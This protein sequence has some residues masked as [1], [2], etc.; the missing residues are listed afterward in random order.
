MKKYFISNFPKNKLIII[1]VISLFI[2]IINI[3]YLVFFEKAKVNNESILIE[4]PYTI[5]N[6]PKP[7]YPPQITNTPKAMDYGYFEDGFDNIDRTINIVTYIKDNGIYSRKIQNYILGKEILLAQNFD[8]VADYT[9]TQD[10][11]F[12]AYSY[13]TGEIKKGDRSEM[14]GS[15]HNVNLLNIN[16]G[17]VKTIFNYEPTK[18]Q[19]ITLTSSPYKNIIFIG[20]DYKRLFIYDINLSKLIEITYKEDETFND[21]N[22]FCIGYKVFDQSPDLS[23]IL[24][25]GYCYE[26]YGFYLYNINTKERI[27]IGYNYAS[28]PSVKK[29][30]DNGSFL[31]HNYDDGELVN[32]GKY[33]YQNQLVQELPITKVDKD[34]DKTQKKI[35]YKNIDK[36]KNIRE[37]YLTSEKEIIE[38]HKDSSVLIKDNQLIGTDISLLKVF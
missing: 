9:L 30:I 25:R 16:T 38:N 31:V 24:L 18:G 12:I 35:Y 6:N 11:K 17:E 21:L 29:F 1:L 20:T 34:D 14:G 2:V 27:T 15:A 28:G 4:Y 7:S 13:A 3:I 26:G 19:I 23:H 5:N 8:Q 33:N 32:V 22:A 37:Y 36:S 10:K